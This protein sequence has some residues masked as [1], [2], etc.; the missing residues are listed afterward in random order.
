[1]SIPNYALGQGLRPY[2]LPHLRNIIGEGALPQ[3]KIEHVGFINFLQSQNKP[4][5]LRLN[6]PAGHKESVQIKYL[7]RLT[8]AYTGTNEA[9]VCN[10]AIVEPYKETTATLNSFRYIA[11]HL[12]DELVAKYENEASNM[13][14]VGGPPTEIMKEMLERLMTAANALLSGVDSDLLTALVAGTNRATGLAT[15]KT[16]NFPLNSTNNDLNADMNEVYSDFAINLLSGQP[17]ILT[18]P[19]SLMHKY[20]LQQRFKSYNQAGINTAIEVAGLNAYID[21]EMGTTFGA[22]NFLAIEKNTVQMV[23][24]LQFTGF[25]AG[26]K[27]GGSVFGTIPLPMQVGQEVKLVE[28][29][30][31]LKYSDCATTLTDGYYGTPITIQKGY[32]L[33]LSKKSGLFQIPTDAYKNIDPNFGSNGVLRY[34]ATN[35]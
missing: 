29:D 11:L 19:G 21:A 7:Q 33:I 9:D 8:K 17:E 1:M 15:A 30:Y 25:K 35:V 3:T 31:Q 6:N 2:I 14:T 16:I 32:N 34:N 20:M 10:T 27:P 4:K 12:D 18:A 13:I 5:V 22:Q 23:E 26:P 24:Y 28:F